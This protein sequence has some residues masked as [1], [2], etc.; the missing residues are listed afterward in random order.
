MTKPNRNPLFRV[1]DPCTPKVGCPI[2]IY[3]SPEQ[4]NV[5]FN[6]EVF[7]KR[8]GPL[9]SYLR[10][11][12]DR[13]IDGKGSPL[14]FQNTYNGHAFTARMSHDQSL[15]ARIELSSDKV[16]DCPDPKKGGAVKSPTME[17]L[18][19]NTTESLHQDSTWSVAGSHNSTLPALARKARSHRAKSQP[20]LYGSHHGSNRTILVL[21]S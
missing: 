2:D 16:T 9:D 20:E 17:I 18:P 19:M 15:V 14:F 7:S 8:L 10:K 5:D 21:A 1:P 6:C 12:P 13:D 11:G 3:F 4:K